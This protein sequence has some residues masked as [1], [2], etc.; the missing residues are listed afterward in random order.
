LALLFENRDALIAQPIER[1]AKRRAPLLRPSGGRHD[2]AAAVE[3]PAADSVTAAPRRPLDDLYFVARRILRKELSV[4][5]Q[6]RQTLLIDV[7]ERVRQSHV[8]VSMMMTIRL[9]VGGD[10]HQLRVCAQLG[11]CA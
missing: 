9:A 6:P 10:V 2:V 1:F 11:K 3:L 4:I 7:I 8:A 5:R